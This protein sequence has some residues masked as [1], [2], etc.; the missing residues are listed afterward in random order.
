MKLNFDEIKKVTFTTLGAAVKHSQSW[1]GWIFV[2]VTWWDDELTDLT[3]I[4]W[5]NAKFY[6]ESAIFR[7]TTTSGQIGT[8]TYFANIL[9]KVC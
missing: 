6:T 2:P 5:Y 8:C 1:G 3:E 7:D 9:K 4:T